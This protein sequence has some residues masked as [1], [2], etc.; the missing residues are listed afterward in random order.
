MH[1]AATVSFVGGFYF[2]GEGVSW[3]DFIRYIN[4]VIVKR[5]SCQVNSS[6]N[7]SVLYFVCTRSAL[8]TFDVNFQNLSQFLHDL[9]DTVSTSHLPS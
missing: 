6:T 9:D 8:G 4:N 1:N 7:T 2:I 3:G 5:I